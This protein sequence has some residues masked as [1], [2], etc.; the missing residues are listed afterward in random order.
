M[1]EDVQYCRLYQGCYMILLQ[2]YVSSALTAS[3][4]STTWVTGPSWSLR[5]SSLCWLLA[6]I[7]HIG[8][9]MEADVGQVLLQTD[10]WD[11]TVHVLDR[12][13]WGRKKLQETE[14]RTRSPWATQHQSLH[15]RRLCA[16]FCNA[17]LADCDRVKAMGEFACDRCHFKWARQQMADISFLHLGINMKYEC[18]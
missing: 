9:D 11:V 12:R 16:V 2:V 17:A 18:L 15:S 1:S 4:I 5:A 7:Q 10:S 6:E 8:V 14:G 3:E 13:R